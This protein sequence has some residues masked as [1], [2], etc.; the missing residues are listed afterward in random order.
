MKTE[1]LIELLSRGAGP[2]PRAVALRRLAPVAVLGLA[3]SVLLSVALLGPIPP[4]MYAGAA[5]WIKLVY[6]ALLAVAAAWLTAR[7]ARPVARLRMPRRAIAA[8]FAI[9]GAVG[10]AA[11]LATAP[12]QRGAALLGQS[13][14]TCPWHVLALS[15]PTLFGALWAV[16]GMAPTR[17][18]AAG[19]AAG[20]FAGAVGAFGYALS[21][22]E[23]SPSFV[24]LWYSLGIG[25]SGAVGA[26]LGPRVLRW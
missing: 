20:L 18:R 12:D 4:A 17:P 2:A 6:A 11:L 1:E 13:W 7:L 3:T 8:V 14:S 5:P 21:C 9:M 16:R 26:L 25:L 22:P 15:L 10:L 24:A 19:F 23:L